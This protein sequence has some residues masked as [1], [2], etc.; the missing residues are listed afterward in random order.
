[1]DT[2][3][4]ALAAGALA[5]VNPCGFAMLP[6]YLALFIAG[7]QPPLGLGSALVAVRRALA[8]T[9]AMTTGFLATFVTAGL[10]L[11]PVAATLQRWAPAL[12]V[13]IG[14]GLAVM[15]LLMVTGRELTLPLPKPGSA[16]NPAAG[17]GPMALYGVVYAVASLGCTIGPFLVVTATT[18]TSGNIPAGIGAYGAYAIGMG[19]VVGVASIS[20]ALARQS[21]T[22][23]LRR[24]LPY[25]AR[26][27]GTLLLL[28]GG[29][30]SWYGIYEL[31]IFA[32]ARVND[33]IINAAARIQA[34]IASLIG[35][36]GPPALAGILAVI[37]VTAGTAVLVGR[38]CRRR[39]SLTNDSADHSAT[40]Q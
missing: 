16:F 35:S 20:V 1:M 8:A 25:A 26:A 34:T 37:L 2:L 21:A 5:A 14:V 40:S 28:A 23:R 33:P 15:G 31:R 7:D 24:L 30:V 6:A 13:V 32:G 4:F 9:A 36:A 39:R 38:A 11:S 27:A 3:G 17:L 19:L 18:F 22:Q 10:V 12:T 29:Y